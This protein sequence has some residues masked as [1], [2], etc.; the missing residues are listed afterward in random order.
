MES[1]KINVGFSPD[2]V[3]NIVL[4]LHHSSVVHSIDEYGGGIGSIYLEEVECTGRENRLIDC[5]Y[6]EFGFTQNNCLHPE[7]AGVICAEASIGNGFSTCNGPFF[8][9]GFFLFY[10]R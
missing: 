4:P 6:T 3:T 5:P 2:L 10:H 9:F 7:D 8:V 1:A